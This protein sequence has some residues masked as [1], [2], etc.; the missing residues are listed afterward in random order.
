MRPVKSNPK[1]VTISWWSN[2]MGLVCLHNLRRHL[3]NAQLYFLQDGKS[4]S[5]K[6]QFREHAPAMAEE[7][8]CPRPNLTDWEAREYLAREVFGQER[9]LWFVD[10]D[11]F[12][13][14]DADRWFDKFADGVERG[15]FVIA[16]PERPHDRCV[17]APCFWLCPEGLPRNVSFAPWSSVATAPTGELVEPEYDTLAR[18]VETVRPP[19]SFKFSLGFDRVLGE[20]FPRHEHVGGLWALRGEDHKRRAPAVY[21]ESLD[22]FRR[23]FAVAPNAWKAVEVDALKRLASAA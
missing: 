15:G 18:L 19:G 7:I 3:P 21:A 22:K 20:H 8:P 2:A 5:E 11:F 10:A 12:L 4:E 16:T 1:L 17:T 9:S 13:L 23:F 14:Q 6:Q